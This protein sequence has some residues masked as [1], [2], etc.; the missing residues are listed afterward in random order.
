MLRVALVANTG[1]PP[2]GNNLNPPVRAF[3]ALCAA[4]LF[5]PSEYPDFTPTGAAAPAPLPRGLLEDIARFAPEVVVCLGGALDVPRPLR[6]F[7][8]GDPVLVGIALSD[9]QALPA[10]L[11]IAPS[12]DLFYSQDQ[13]SLPRYASHGV[14]AR[15]L[16]LAADPGTLFPTTGVK[17]CDVLYFGKWTEYRNDLVCAAARVATVQVLAYRGETR[18]RLP[19][20]PQADDEATL[21]QEINR[22]RLVLDPTR[23]ELM[24]DA[25]TDA[26]RIT[27]RAFMAAACAV[28]A[29]VEERCPLE[30]A[31]VP[32]E[33]IATFDGTPEGVVAVARE[34][35]GD[36]A[37]RERMGEAARRRLLASHT[38]VHRARQVLGD[39]VGLRP[40]LAAARPGKGQSP[41]CR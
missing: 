29:L 31:F 10:S 33:E 41:P 8:P 37:R 22:A 32:G 1:Q 19:V 4:R 7:L 2:Y 23:V 39:V 30:G 6:A 25:A 38:W 15:F 40:A 36:G 14:A 13:E 21:G 28:P 12:F 16:P 27:P 11:Q 24:P 5:V 18:W 34:L 9:P 35:L 3:A 20:A 17:S 26:Y